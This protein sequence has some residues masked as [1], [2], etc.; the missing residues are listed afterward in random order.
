MHHF[1]E[2]LLLKYREEL[3][4]L[5]FTILNN[6]F[7]DLSKEERLRGRR[8]GLIYAIEAAVA[9]YKETYNTKRINQGVT[10]DE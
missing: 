6:S 9:T 7:T 10:D 8:D 5:E 1:Y 2:N 3:K 4:G